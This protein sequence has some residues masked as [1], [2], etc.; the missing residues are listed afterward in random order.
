M[1]AAVFS[2]TGG[3][4]VLGYEQVPTPSVASGEVLIA[5]ESVSVNQ[6]LDLQIRSGVSR[7][8]VRLP[9]ILGVDRRVRAPRIDWSGL[10]A[11]RGP[12]RNLPASRDRG[13]GLKSD[14]GARR[15]PGLYF[16]AR[17]PPGLN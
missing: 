4:E 5:V 9:H 15:G 3:P 14:R 1:R 12:N 11:L 16:S 2:R 8:G 7:R 6:T 10:V 17:T 13:T